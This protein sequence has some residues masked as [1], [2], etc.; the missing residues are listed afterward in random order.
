VRIALVGDSTM[1]AKSGGENGFK[2][3]FNESAALLNLSL[4]GEL[5]EFQ[6]EGHWVMPCANIHSHPRAVRPQ[7]PAGKGLDRETDLPTF[8]ANMA[9]YVDEAR[10]R[11]GRNRFGHA[12]HSTILR[13]RRQNPL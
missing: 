9:R 2:A 5:E 7:R 1:T 4:G 13:R 11:R 10:G 12:A 8:R 3:R 6:A